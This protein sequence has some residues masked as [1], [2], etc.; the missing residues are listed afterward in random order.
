[1]ITF[2]LTHSGFLQNKNLILTFFFVSEDLLKKFRAL[3]FSIKQHLPLGAAEKVMWFWFT[4]LAEPH[5]ITQRA[6]GPEN[7][8]CKSDNMCKMRWFF[9]LVLRIWEK[10]NKSLSIFCCFKRWVSKRLT[11]VRKR[12]F[13]TYWGL[14]FRVLKGVNP[15]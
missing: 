11:H 5:S 4:R 9:Q 13:S 14:C 3:T 12:Q 8:S 2:S 7:L 1:M 6:T 10:H 15:I